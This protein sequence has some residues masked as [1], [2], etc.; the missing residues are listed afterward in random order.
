MANFRWPAEWEPQD[1]VL[2]AWPHEGT[3]WA[4]TLAAVED[5]YVA[6]VAAIARRETAL[7]C[8]ADAALQAH[9]RGRLAEAG[10]A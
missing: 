2:L 10:E 1:A 4:D 9:A 6:L 3:D 8:V 5:S 7:V